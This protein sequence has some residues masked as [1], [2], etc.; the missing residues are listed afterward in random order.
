[1]ISSTRQPNLSSSAL[2]Q[3]RVD[4]QAHSKKAHSVVGSSDECL[5]SL[6]DDSATE[7][8][9]DEDVP[10]TSSPTLRDTVNPNAPPLPLKQVIVFV[11]IGLPF[12]TFFSLVIHALI[13][14]TY[15]LNHLLA[16]SSW[17]VHVAYKSTPPS[18][19][20]FVTIKER[21]FN[22]FMNNTK[23]AEVASLVMTWV[24]VSII[25]PV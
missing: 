19:N 10:R 6:D 9:S 22:S 24:S 25:I 5:L 14:K 20:G 3:S 12:L 7:P 21:A 1:M 15:L 23:R 13:S 17:I 2:P 18:I 11:C 4:T 16:H 8:D